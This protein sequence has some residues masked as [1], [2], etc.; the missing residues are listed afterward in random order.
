MAVLILHFRPTRHQLKT[1][2]IALSQCFKIL[3][4]NVSGAP[5]VATE[6]ELGRNIS[7]ILSDLP[8]I[9]QKNLWVFSNI[10][11]EGNAGGIKHNCTVWEKFYIE[12]IFYVKNMMISKVSDISALK[13]VHNAEKNCVAD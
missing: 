8:K 9:C 7:A 2:L 10:K 11:T 13:T 4:C 3:N 6:A 5:S 12:A 1:I